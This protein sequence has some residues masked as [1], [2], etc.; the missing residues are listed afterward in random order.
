[1]NKLNK[2]Q[3][4]E[5]ESHI[6]SIRNAFTALGTKIEAYNAHEGC[7]VSKAELTAAFAF[8]DEKVE[9]AEDFRSGIASDIRDAFD[10]KS[11]KW[12]D[13]DNGQ[14]VGSFA[15]EWEGQEFSGLGFTVPEEFDELSIDEFDSGAA[16]DLENMPNEA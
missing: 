12:Q 7:K 16:D 9:A 10:N 6:N 5:K 13:S 11:E 1:M 15:D 8:F 3:L 2:K 4:A 14:S